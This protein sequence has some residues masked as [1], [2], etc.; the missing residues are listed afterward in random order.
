V[1]D[2]ARGVV[3]AYRLVAD[4]NDVTLDVHIPDDLL[5]TADRS[6]M[7]QVLAN[8]I[9]NAVKYTPRGGHVAV[10]AAHI[11]PDDGA[12]AV[13]IE[14][15]DDGIGI[16]EDEQPRIWDR[17]YRGDQSR[18]E[19]GTG[20][21]LSFVKAIVEAH[22]GEVSVESRPGDGATFRVDLPAGNGTA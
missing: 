11:D 15:C 14:V 6:R 19:E 13:R 10:R 4:A 21:G 3:E 18:S 12:P 16:P 22:D 20:L 9:D 2:L 17:L 5:V 7:R 8:L 1:D